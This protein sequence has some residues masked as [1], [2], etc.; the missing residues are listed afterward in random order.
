N[1][2]SGQNDNN[3]F[4]DKQPFHHI[5]HD[6]NTVKQEFESNKIS[7]FHAPK[8]K[9]KRKNRSLISTLLTILA[10]SIIG[11]L[12]GVGILQMFVVL[13]DQ[14]AASEITQNIS[15]PTAA[16]ERERKTTPFQIPKLSA[17]IVQA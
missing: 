17:Y 13:N 16:G 14:P 12:F 10:A 5:V 7:V 2:N 15:Q 6:E 3:K 8:L 9:K 1:M 11:V 4:E